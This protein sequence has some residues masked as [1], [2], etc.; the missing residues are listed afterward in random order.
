MRVER[1]IFWI[2]DLLLLGFLTILTCRPE[3]AASDGSEEGSDDEDQD[4]RI[5]SEPTRHSVR[6]F[7]GKRETRESSEGKKPES[8]EI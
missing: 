1:Q 6:E 3:Y 7:V 4:I 2:F 8:F 5:V